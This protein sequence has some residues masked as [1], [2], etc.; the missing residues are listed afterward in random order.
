ML[1]V[2]NGDV[3]TKREL[4]HGWLGGVVSRTLDSQLWSWLQF[5]VMTL[6]GYY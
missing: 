5:P 6:P 1:M 3:V 4:F 2:V